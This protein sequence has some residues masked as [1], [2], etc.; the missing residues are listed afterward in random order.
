MQIHPAQTHRSHVPGK[1]FSLAN[2]I[3][4]TTTAIKSAGGHLGRFL[5]GVTEKHRHGL[6]RQGVAKAGTEMVVETRGKRTPHVATKMPFINT[7]YYR[8]SE[9][10]DAYITRVR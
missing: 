2:T 7:T 5:P 6:C 10:H 3:Y 8:P 4:W 9:R 1:G